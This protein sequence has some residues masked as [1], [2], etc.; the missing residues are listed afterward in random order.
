MKLFIASLLVL[1][2]TCQAAMA[3]CD[4]TKVVANPDGTYTYSKELHICVGKMK[5]DLGAANDQLVA[6]KE[7]ITLKD[8]ALTDANQR[9]LL[10]QDTATKD[11]ERI[12][13][14]DNIENRNKVI[15]IGLGVVG[16]V[17][18]VWAAGQIARK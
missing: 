13:T 16:T 11:L 12:N 1:A 4:Y 3:D 5:K 10:W 17:L 15:Y 9:A 8:L 2:L 7:A 18:A 14:I 6:Y